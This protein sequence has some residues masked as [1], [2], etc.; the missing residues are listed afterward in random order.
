MGSETP[1]FFLNFVETQVDL[2]GGTFKHNVDW[3]FEPFIVS[4]METLTTP[5]VQKY[6]KFPRSTQFLLFRKTLVNP[7]F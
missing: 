1:F 5:T 3:N 6:W 7:V 2:E 4:N